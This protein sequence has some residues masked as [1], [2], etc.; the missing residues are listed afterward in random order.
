MKV[1]HYDKEYIEAIE[2]VSEKVSVEAWS[3]LGYRSGVMVVY[4]HNGP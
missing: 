2:T 1:Q 4:L 3:N